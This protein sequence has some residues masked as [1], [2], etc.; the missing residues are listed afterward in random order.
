MV[1]ARVFLDS[2]LRCGFQGLIEMARDTG[3]RVEEKSE[4][5]MTLF[6]NKKQTKF[7]LMIGKHYIVYYSNGHRRIPLEAVQH[8]PE[9]F[10]GKQI[11]V[12]KAIEKQILKSRSKLVR[13][14]TAA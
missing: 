4:G 13:L 7:K 9:F 11:D 1:I 3:W 5:T 6:I 2:D 10:N 8:F 14:K 12:S